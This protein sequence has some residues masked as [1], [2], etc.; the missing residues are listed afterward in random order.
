[1]SPETPF[2]SVILPTY[3]RNR[4]LRRAVA[5]VLCQTFRE[6]ELIV[7]DDGSTEDVEAALSAYRHRL[8]LITT[9]HRG[10]SAARNEGIRVS[11]GTHIAFLD[12]DDVWLP[13]K[14][15]VQ[16]AFFRNMPRARICQTQEIWIRNGVRVNPMKKHEKLSGNIFKN[17]LDLCIVSP[18]AVMLHRELFDRFG[19]F[20]ES[21]QACEDYDLWI[22]ISPHYPVY[23]LEPPL[24][25]KHGGHEDQQSKRIK[26]L[27]RLRI[28]AICKALESGGLTDG[29]YGLA[30]QALEK[31]CRIYGQGCLKRGRIREG[32][33]F[34]KLPE[35]YRRYRKRSS[36]SQANRYE[37]VSTHCRS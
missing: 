12:S 33:Y 5:S 30:R 36:L 35:V 21:M 10:P 13:E 37:P 15:A 16:T 24:V 17:C 14:L 29:Q 11:Q 6:V 23:L 2:V 1:M 19:L 3:N 25:V 9:P 20:D 4:F 28:K 32:E 34:L 18:S 31:K 7:V 22:R 26:Q 8:R 27:D